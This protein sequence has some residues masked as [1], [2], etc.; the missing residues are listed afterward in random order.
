MVLLQIT[1]TLNTHSH[2]IWDNAFFYLFI[3]AI[4]LFTV[5]ILV[6]M[7]VLK[8]KNI[9]IV[10]LQ[11][12]HVAKIDIIRKEHSNKLENLRIE[13]LRRE[14][15]RSRQWMESEKETLHVLNGVSNLLDLTNVVGRA[16]SQKI[17]SILDEIQI[18][19]ALIKTNQ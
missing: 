6:V 7:R 14:E 13:M 3:L 16:D 1:E 2:I 10:F 9:N 18:K 12:Q 8:K 4:V 19:I 15:D 11:Q 5:G 17:L